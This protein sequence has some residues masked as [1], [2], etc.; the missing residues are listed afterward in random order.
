MAATAAQVEPSELNEAQRNSEALKVALASLVGSII[1]WYD[2]FLYVIAASLFFREL[3][4]PQMSP[5]MGTIVSLSTIG[6]GYIARPLG[7]I[8]MGHFG[9]KLGRKAMLVSS[10]IIMG[11]ATTIIGLLPTFATIGTAAPLILVAARLLQGFAVGG[12]V[13]G[14]ITMAV[15]FAPDRRRGL[16]GGFPQ[17]G[18]ASGLV[19]AN[20]I[21][22]ACTA[23][24]TT[25]QFNSFGW[26]IPFL[27]SIVLVLIGIYVRLQISESPIF[28]LMKKAGKET[29]IPLVTLFERAWKEIGIVALSTLFTNVM[30]FLGL[31]Y[32]LAYATT[33]LGFTRPTILT[34]IIIANLIEI[35]ATLYFAHLSDQVGRRKVY[36]WAL[37]FAM[38]W[39]AVFFPLVDT[40]IPIVVFVAIL[41]ARLCIAAIFGPQAALFSELFDTNIRYSGIS[42]GYSISSIIGA[43]TP[44]L[45]AWLVFATGGSLALS[46]L[47]FV[48]A[49]ISFVTALFLWETYKVDL[50]AKLD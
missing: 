38:V 4:F 10:L 7:A 46:G 5:L 18:V 14:A 36:L 21:L 25:E 11:A 45:A 32:M 39:G 23:L 13:G 8:I 6:V 47:I 43:Q 34:F 2:F 28:K 9:D 27:L 37:G 35:P 33:K 20:V 49:L 31:F 30:G 42:V 44:P 22:L 19:L 17:L 48:A 15:E 50:H 41:V 1:E 12:E 29:M 3:F 24:L 16:F 26:R 40:Q